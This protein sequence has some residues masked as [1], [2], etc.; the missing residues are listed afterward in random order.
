MYATTPPIN[1]AMI[2]AHKPLTDPL[3]QQEIANLL[4]NFDVNQT[5]ITTWKTQP[6]IDEFLQWIT[7][8]NHT[9]VRGLESFKHGALCNGTSSA[10]ETFIQRNNKRRIRFSC[11][12]FVLSKIVSNSIGAQWCYLENDVLTTNDAV[13]LSYPFSGNGTVL[14][15]LDQV[16]AQC[17]E[18][19]IPVLVDLAYIG[20][21]HNLVIDITAPCITDVTT[22]ISKPFATMLRHGVRFT[23]QYYDD[24][25]QSSSDIGILP[26]INIVIA[27]QLMQKFSKDYIVDRYISKYLQICKDLELLPTNTITLAI[28]DNE[29]YPEFVRGGTARIC[30]TDE[31]LS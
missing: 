19:N 24:N 17:T 12:E 23:K 9:Q 22:S 16:L 8:G 18:K 28:G 3:V 7:H 13:V 30:V 1:I 4:K 31:L 29:K 2:L 10:I 6:Y 15:N 20:I 27:T 14:P 26:R 21:G 5:D 25:I 11:A